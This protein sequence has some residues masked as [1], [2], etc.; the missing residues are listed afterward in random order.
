MEIQLNKD[1]YDLQLFQ[2]FVR[3]K[4]P[5]TFVRFS[6][7]ETEILQNNKLSIN[8]DSV[9]FQG[10][11]FSYEYP[12]FDS[13]SFVPE[14]DKALHD[15]LMKSVTYSSPTYIKGVPGAHNG[16]KNREYYLDLIDCHDMIT[17]C[18]ILHNNNYYF[19]VKHF[20]PVVL[21]NKNVFCIA[22]E[23][24]QNLD[25]FSKIIRVP[26]NAFPN[27]LAVKYEIL[28]SVRNVP[29]NSIILSS[30]SS[31]SNVIGWLLNAER[32]D[33]TFIDV[34]SG[35]NHLLGLQKVTRVYHVGV[36]GPRSLKDLKQFVSHK[37]LRKGVMR[38]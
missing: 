38:W 9:Y 36:F 37:I 32:P 14:R 1:R 31:F 4:N 33:I 29:R 13:K 25:I 10:K 3:Q 21:S 17:L 19:F 26:T 12:T 5:F 35:I 8:V 20:L 23:N 34:G 24:A 30:A 22:N 15:D 6:D 16:V 7:G 11:K 28:E 27:Y 18:D 2:K